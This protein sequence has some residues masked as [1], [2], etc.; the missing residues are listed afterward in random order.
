MRDI[1]RQTAFRPLLWRWPLLSALLMMAACGGTPPP[2][3]QQLLASAQAAIQKAHAYHFNLQTQHAGTSANLVLQSADGD[4]VVPDKLQAN[5]TAQVFGSLVQIKIITIGQ[6]QYM[7]DPITGRWETTSGLPDAQTL[8]SSQ[9]GIAGLLGHIQNPS[10]PS[11]SSVDGV[12]CWST[13]GKLDAQYLSGILGNQAKAGSLLDA[14]TCIGTSD[15]LPYLIRLTGIA[16]AGDSSQTVRTLKLS[17]FNEA[18]T[19][20]APAL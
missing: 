8:S 14:T 18:I 9:T 19:I 13:S 16:T 10:T 20:N 11:N 3:A 5:A 17:K 2:S 15:H 12:S 6:H 4:L 1:A 7:T